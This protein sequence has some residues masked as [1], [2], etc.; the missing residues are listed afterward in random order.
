MEPEK[1]TILYIDD[2]TINLELFDAVFEDL[3]NVITLTSSFEADE[4]LKNNPVKVIISDQCMPF[5]TGLEFIKRINGD[6]PDVIKII[7][8]AFENHEVALEAINETGIYKYLLKPWEKSEVKNSLDNAIR[9]YDLRRENKELLI[10]L[11]LKNEALVVAYDQLEAN[12]KKFYTIFAKNNDSIYILNHKKEIIEANEAFH[13]LVGY[14]TNSAD[15]KLLSAFIK[16]RFP[17]LLD[18][19][20]DLS[21]NANTAAIETDI[22]VGTNDIRYLELN[23]NDISYNGENYI[24]AVIRDIS[25]RRMFEKKIVEAIIQTQE[26]DQSKYAREL[27]D[28]LGPLLSTL[29][30]HIEWIADPVN[31]LNKDKIMQ[32]SILAIDNAI[33]SVKEIA[34]NL[35]PH[36]LQRFGLVNA[37]QSYIDHVRETSPIEFLVS[38]NLKERVSANVEI[39]LYRTILEC[40]NNSVKHSE[41]KKI[42]LKFNKHQSMLQIGYSDNGKGFDA[43]EVMAN[44]RGMGLFNIQNRVKHIGGEF[45][46]VSNCDIGTDINIYLNIG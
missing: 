22:K 13:N 27:H 16:S 11:K 21:R 44:G 5:E 2:D 38:S 42:I 20:I 34:N 6:Y 15:F 12:E 8:T 40:I 46:I 4:V 39:V 31:S 29:K 3:Y 25:E 23:C 7:L 33:R 35:S 18:K 32:H 28:G 45:K 24:L 41:A 9:E 30:M 37:V 17:A 14:K 10:E 43:A 1:D 19:P 26:E 36:I